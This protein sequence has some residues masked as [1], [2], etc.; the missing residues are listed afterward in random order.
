MDQ[1]ISRK[2]STPNTIKVEFSPSGALTQGYDT[3]MVL[4]SGISDVT[5]LDQLGDVIE[6]AFT[7]DGST[8]VYQANTSTYIVK[9]MNI[10]GGSF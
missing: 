1:D 9:P 7:E 2:F 10:D 3:G 4:K 8:L 5:K 6:P